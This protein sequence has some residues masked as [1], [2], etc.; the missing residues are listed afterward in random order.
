MKQNVLS[1]DIYSFIYSEGNANY[2]LQEKVN[3]SVNINSR[4]NF[5]ICQLFTIGQMTEILSKHYI[6]NIVVDISPDIILKN[7]KTGEIVFV[8]T[9]DELCDALWES[10]KFH[11]RNHKN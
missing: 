1:S 9:E 11:Y 2:D 6:L 5:P 3:L 7:K 4:N 10:L 8:S